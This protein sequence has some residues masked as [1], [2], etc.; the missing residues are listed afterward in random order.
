MTL[1]ISRVYHDTFPDSIKIE[2]EG[3]VGDITAKL[4]LSVKYVD[5]LVPKLNVEDTLE[6]DVDE[7]VEKAYRVP[8]LEDKRHDT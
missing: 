5:G 7:L 2:A 4:Q 1:K 8:L 6:L 3:R